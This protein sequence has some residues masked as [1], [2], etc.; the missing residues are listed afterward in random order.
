MKTTASAPTATRFIGNCQICEG[1]QKLHHGG[2]VHHGYRR[3]GD[4]YIV[5]DC[6]GVGQV[7]Y[8]VSC[9]LVKSHRSLVGT[10]LVS[11]KKY[12]AR[13]QAGDVTRLTKIEHRGGWGTMGKN[14]L[15]EYIAGVTEP[16]RWAR[17]VESA[18]WEVQSTVRQCEADIERCTRRI[19][20]WKPMPIRT[21][22]EEVCKEEMAKAE[23][24][25]I[26]ADK[27][28]AKVAKRAATDA[29][30]E[31]RE[32]TRTA[33]RKDFEAKFR[34]LAADSNVTLANRQVNARGLLAEMEKTKYRNWLWL[35]T[36]ECEEAFVALGLAVQ[37]GVNG[38]GRPY[39]RWL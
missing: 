36:L 14:E 20:A 21:V 33:I 2:M 18:T 4:G 6:P 32:A 25:K 10:K 16:Y 28:A 29:K 17:A 24:A 23:R 19:N 35:S 26:V 37:D 5:G 9:D 13:L 1:D 34:A 22:E 31:A 8:E 27:R 11:S 38:R 3:P 30:T 15:I 12:L 7:P 39:L